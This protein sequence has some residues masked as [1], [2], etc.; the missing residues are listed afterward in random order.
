[1]RATRPFGFHVAA[2]Y[3]DRHSK[4]GVWAVSQNFWLSALQIYNLLGTRT[5]PRFKFLMSCIA[6]R[7][8]RKDNSFTCMIW[9][10]RKNAMIGFL[11][12]CGRLSNFYSKLARWIILL[13]VFQVCPPL[14]LRLA[15]MWRAW[16]LRTL[17]TSGVRNLVLGLNWPMSWSKRKRSW[18]PRCQIVGVA[19]WTPKGC[20]W[21]STS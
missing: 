12:S 5:T 21:W 9:R 15:M 17:S 2:N 1:M 13:T 10:P 3:S 7:A 14:W 6:P 4:R 20:C 8:V 19:F 16:D 18:S 11:V